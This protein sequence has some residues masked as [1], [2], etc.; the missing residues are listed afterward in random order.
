MRT[1]CLG[2]ALVDLVCE[3]PVDGL[4][5]AE[6]FVPH[7]G[8]AV[9]NAAVVAARCGAA[10]ALG[11]GVGDDAWGE[12]LE[13]RMRSEGVDL[14]W[15]TRVPGVATPL[16][17]VT[18]NHA[19][20]PDF[21]VYGQTI[22]KT[23]QSIEADLEAAVRSCDAL[24]F[25]SNTLV[26]ESERALTLSARE[27]AL[28][29]GKPVLF[30]P[31]LRL[32]RW[33]DPRQAIEVV[34]AACDGALLVKVNRDEAARLTG[35]RE[36]EQAAEA[37]CALGAG[38]AVI[39]LGTDGALARGAVHAAVGGFPVHPIDTTGAGDV[40]AGVLIAALAAKGF[41]PSA[42]TSAL[43]VAIEAASRSTEGWGA[44]DSLPDMPEP[45]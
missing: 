39:T 43:P 19:G 30:D 10:V 18:V 20:E 45:A 8:G 24:F 14:T 34:R 4:A 9:A 23:M 13:G 28:D 40:V 21:V 5:D 32:H 27:L 22:P 6:A 15:F 41:D 29:A 26:G 17:F 11:G 31:N 7:S 36:P 42:I 12:W 44:I 35:Q 25:G 1:L 3:H 38:T 16:A 2:E 37:L 33:A